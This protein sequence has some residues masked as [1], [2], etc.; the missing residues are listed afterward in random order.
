MLRWGCVMGTV[1]EGVDAG[2]G[3]VRKDLIE[4]FTFYELVAV[5]H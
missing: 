3:T 5:S 2:A 4:E 1:K